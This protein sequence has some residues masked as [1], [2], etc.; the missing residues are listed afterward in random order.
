MD[1]DQRPPGT[2]VACVGLPVIQTGIQGMRKERAL[3]P[4]PPLPL[5]PEPDI[6]ADLST[7]LPAPPLEYPAI[8]LYRVWN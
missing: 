4:E 6:G 8:Q 3:A 7:D 1:I 5:P 2:S